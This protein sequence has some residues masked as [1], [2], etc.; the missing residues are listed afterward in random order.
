MDS[1]R[2]HWEEGQAGFPKLRRC[3]AGYCRQR[4]KRWSRWK[5][6]AGSFLKDKPWRLCLEVYRIKEPLGPI[7]SPSNACFKPSTSISGCQ[8]RICISF[9]LG[10]SAEESQGQGWFESSCLRR[11]HS[12]GTSLPSPSLLQQGTDCSHAIRAWAEQVY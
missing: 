7:L 10:W 5:G 2:K 6:H 4:N 12:P 9:R 1:V 3:E 11:F 8:H